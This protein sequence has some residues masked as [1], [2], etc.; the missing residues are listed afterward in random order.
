MEKVR[1]YLIYSSSVHINVYTHMNM[2]IRMNIYF[3]VNLSLHS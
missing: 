3:T 1:V 2:C